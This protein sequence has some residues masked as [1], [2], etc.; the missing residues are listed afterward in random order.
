MAED[1]RIVFRRQSALDL[2]AALAHFDARIGQHPER[3][4]APRVNLDAAEEADIDGP[5]TFAIPVKIRILGRPGGKEL[6]RPGAVGGVVGIAIDDHID[7]HER[8]VGIDPFL[9]GVIVAF[10]RRLLRQPGADFRI[11][12]DAR[13]QRYREIE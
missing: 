3:Q 5:R 2:A 6:V 8:R 9:I 12:H 4:L 10:S 13:G 1:A 11:T 7:I